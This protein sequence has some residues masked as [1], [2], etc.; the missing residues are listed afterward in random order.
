MVKWIAAFHATFMTHPITDLWEHGGYWDHVKRNPKSDAGWHAPKTDLE[1]EL[2]KHAAQLHA[3]VSSCK[4]NVLIHGDPKIENFCFSPDQKTAAG[5]DYQFVGHGPGV[6]D[7]Y[8]LIT[9]CCNDENVIEKIIAAYFGYLREFLPN[10][11][12]FS[13]LE[14][15]WRALWPFVVADYERFLLGRYYTHYK[16][17]EY[18]TLICKTALEK[19]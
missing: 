19:L 2:V 3:K 12:H 6:K 16:R 10:F 1:K 4:F 11:A 7:L 14:A 15:E 8:Y 13:A 5:L 18:S 17:T 9:S